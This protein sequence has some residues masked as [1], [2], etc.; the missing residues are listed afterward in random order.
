MRI[1]DLLLLFTVVALCVP[2]TAALFGRKKKGKDNDDDGLIFGGGD[3]AKLGLNHLHQASQSGD[4]LQNAMAMMND[5][6]V[7]AE[8]E[9]L[10]N[11]P[12]FKAEMERLTNNPQFQQAVQQA[13]E[14]LQDGS[15]DMLNDPEVYAEYLKMFSS[16]EDN[17]ARGIEQMR[18]IL[19]DTK[20]L[21]AAMEMLSDPKAMEEVQKMMMDPEFQAEVARYTDTPQFKQA[22]K[23]AEQQMSD[24]LNNPDKA[25]TFQRQMEE[26]GKLLKA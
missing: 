22:M 8:V 14:L 5:P 1:L 20:E 3:S 12:E 25:A 24:L 11:D 9:K 17:A 6:E 23:N 2:G 21:E 26:M 10:M 15:L 13:A 16:P 4:E 18:S 19:G 7:M